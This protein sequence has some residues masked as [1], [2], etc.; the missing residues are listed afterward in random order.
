M[1]LQR[2]REQRAHTNES[3]TGRLTGPA[4]PAWCRARAPPQQQLARRR[5][6]QQPARKKRR[7]TASRDSVLPAAVAPSGGGGG[8]VHVRLGVHQP[9]PRRGV[10]HFG[11]HDECGRGCVVVTC[12]CLR[13]PLRTPTPAPRRHGGPPL[14]T[15]TSAPRRHCG[16]HIKWVRGAFLLIGLVHTSPLG[17]ISTATTSWKPSAGRDERGRG[18]AHTGTWTTDWAATTWRQTQTRWPSP[19]VRCSCW[20]C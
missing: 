16:G 7:A 4:L 6:C 11:R 3:P 1:R 8:V 19:H 17:R 20:P 15:P 18:S 2:S 9:A 12:P 14:R 5:R 13:P 10:A